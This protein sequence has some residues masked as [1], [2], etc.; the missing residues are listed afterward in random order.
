MAKNKVMISVEVLNALAPQR[1][2]LTGA[3]KDLLD[4]TF[5]FH[6]VSAREADTE[7]SLVE[8]SEDNQLVR[9]RYVNKESNKSFIIPIRGL[10]NL[11][12]AALK[13]TDN[14][15]FDPENTD[16]VKMH[17]HLLESISGKEEIALPPQFKIVHVAERRQEGTDNIMYP[18][19]CYKAF[20]E[21]ADKL[22]KDPENKTGILSLYQDIAFM[23]SLHT[24]KAEDR[25]ARH[26]SAEATKTIT[27]AI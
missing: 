13:A 27:I 17:E 5:V 14:E 24:G 22:N 2:L 23:Q 11:D 10:L 3:V 15:E 7:T 20:N 25:E 4:Q 19:Y 16:T 8:A 6:S 18:P 12:V 9:A 1:G 26:Q 21:R